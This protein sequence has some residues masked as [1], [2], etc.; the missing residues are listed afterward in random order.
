[1]INEFITN[2][3]KEI[4]SMSKKIVKNNDYEEVAHYVITIFLVTPNAKELIKRGEAMKFLSGMIFRSYHSKTSPFYKLYRQNGIMVS[5]EEMNHHY[6]DDSIDEQEHEMLINKI[7]N[8]LNAR[9]DD[10]NK[11][12]MITLFKMYIHT[13]NY[14]KLAR[15]T[16]IPRTTISSAVKEAKQYIKNKIKE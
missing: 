8:I 11:W 3:Y 10:I 1:V 13:Q 4:L 9:Y 15:E 7:E 5:G 12:F 2:H 14:S 16:K 6:I